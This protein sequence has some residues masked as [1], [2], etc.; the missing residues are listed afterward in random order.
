[1]PRLGGRCRACSLTHHP[2]HPS[3]L[4]PPRPRVHLQAE[5]DDL[6]P[7][8]VDAELRVVDQLVPREPI[9]E[10]NAV[11]EIRAGTGGREA[12]LFTLDLWKMYER[13]RAGHRAHIIGRANHS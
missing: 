11:L 5:Y 7:T 9:D 4:T 2:S 8:L 1:M 10:G 3:T 6:L 12:A 13:V